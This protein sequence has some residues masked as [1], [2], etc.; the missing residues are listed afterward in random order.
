M[1]EI[2]AFDYD[3]EPCEQRSTKPEPQGQREIASGSTRQDICSDLSEH[4]GFSPPL[5]TPSGIRGS[6][7]SINTTPDDEDGSI[8]E[9]RHWIREFVTQKLEIHPPPPVP[10][11]V[12]ED[13]RNT[14]DHNNLTSGVGWNGQS[15]DNPNSSTPLVKVKGRNNSA[16]AT[17]ALKI[18]ASE[19]LS[20]EEDNTSLEY[21]KKSMTVTPI[22]RPRR[23]KKWV[24]ASFLIFPLLLFFSTIGAKSMYGFGLQPDPAYNPDEIILQTNPTGSP[25]GDYEGAI[26][27]GLSANIS[28]E[29]LSKELPAPTPVPMIFDH[30]VLTQIQRDR[31]YKASLEYLA[32]NEYEAVYIARSM[33]YVKNEGHPAT[34]CGP[35][36]I[37]L[38]RDAV[39]VD[40]YVDLQ[41]FWLLNPRNEYTV[42]GV[43]EKY[44]PREHYQWYKTDTPVNYFDFKEFPL[45][46]GDFVYLFAGAGGTFEHMITVTRVDDSGRAYSV[47]TREN[48]NGYSISEVMLYDP[49]N[50]GEGFFYEVT[51]RSNK[52]FGLTG[53]GGFWMWRRLTPIPEEN[54]DDLAFSDTLDSVLKE[55]GGEWNVLIKEIDGRIIYSRQADDLIHP[56]SVIKVPLAIQFFKALNYQGEDDL[57][58]YLSERGI[59]GRTYLQLIRAML[60][61]SEEAATNILYE[62]VNE[63]IHIVDVFARWGVL[64]T[65]YKPRISTAEEMGILF[66]GLYQGMWLE[67]KEREIILDLL[68]EYTLSDDTRLGVIRQ[69]LPGDSRFYNKRGSILEGRIVV[70]D[71]AVIEVG[72][73][74]FLVAMFGYPGEEDLAPFYEKLETVIENAAYVI[75]EYLSQQ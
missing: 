48:S 28:G 71:V 1:D 73:K 17:S 6:N 51:D 31:L 22:P 65:A 26:S 14:D 47:T 11:Q 70:A 45:Y 52:D 58:Q 24:Y 23:N 7:Q 16:V 27:L 66:E 29:P 74:A 59:K 56:A 46:T 41:S 2:K 21:G 55:Y 42:R 4:L 13:G 20:I 38:L 60:V 40:R 49:N 57:H 68:A 15:R 30:S 69:L 8:S 5:P 63:R 33:E 61:D 18:R 39:L 19:L 3:D 62:W 75:W 9:Y 72:D 36:A 25:E 50:P 10:S 64:D 67:P 54:L 32:E 53:F 12:K 35:L 37:G 43:L 34:M 44:F